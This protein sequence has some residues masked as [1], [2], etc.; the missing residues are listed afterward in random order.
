MT[1]TFYTFHI[2]EIIHREHSD[3]TMHVLELLGK[4]AF[5]AA[6][7]TRN[8]NDPGTLR[9]GY[10]RDLPLNELRS[11]ANAATIPPRFEV[12]QRFSAM[13]LVACNCEWSK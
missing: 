2:K 1:E 11:R 13:S 10:W 6:T 7:G 12:R 4:T 9:L 8:A 3:S 5:S